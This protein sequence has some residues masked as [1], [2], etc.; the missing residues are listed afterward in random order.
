MA[1]RIPLDDL[2]LQMIQTN[3][4][5]G[6]LPDGLRYKLIRKLKDK[7]EKN[8]DGTEKIT[9]Q[10]EEIG[11]VLAIYTR[12]IRLSNIEGNELFLVQDSLALATDCLT[13]TMPEASLSFMNVAAS[14]TEPSQG[15]K[16]FLRKLMNSVFTYQSTTQNKSKKS[17]F[18]GDSKNE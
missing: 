14:I 3:P 5:W 15:K 12:D 8:A 10:A 18:G 1:D 7:I 4:G 17:F 9:P 2:D 6:E 13:M 16:G 11:D